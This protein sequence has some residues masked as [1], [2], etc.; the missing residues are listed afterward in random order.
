MNLIAYY[1][2]YFVFGLAFAWLNLTLQSA[3]LTSLLTSSLLVLQVALLAIN[4]T[5]R[6]ALLSK[7][8]ELGND[9]KAK[10]QS[11]VKAMN[12]ALIEQ[13]LII[14]FTGLILIIYL[15]PN[16]LTNPSMRMVSEAL[17]VG[18]LMA[19]IQI[20][21]DTSKAIMIILEDQVK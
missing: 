16:V 6:T 9:F 4:T 10:F 2:M 1:S 11:T 8:K 18:L 14:F 17:L 3:F 7:L 13:I 19:S 15:S 12:E 20:V 21:F 5:A